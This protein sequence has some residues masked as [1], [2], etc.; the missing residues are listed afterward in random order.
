L[1]TETFGQRIR[2]LRRERRLDQRTLAER[3]QARLDPEGRR[4]FGFTYL[5]KIENDQVSP[6]ST[7]VVIELAGELG[8]DADELLALAGKAP[9]DL[10]QTLQESPA[11]RMFLRSAQQLD[12]SEQEWNE[13][14]EELKRKRQHER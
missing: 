8:D 3:V 9:P 14:L 12:L 6:P 2:R 10:E 4:G 11:A 5:S 13:L 1:P 7:A